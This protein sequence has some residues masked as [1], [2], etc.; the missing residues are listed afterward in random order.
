MKLKRQS[1]CIY[2]CEYHLVLVTKYR[3]KIFNNGIH[4]YMADRLKGL[5]KSYPELEILKINHDEDHIHILISI[6][7]KM[8]VGS[9]V[10]I[11]KS[12]TAKQLKEKFEFLKEVYWGTASI[13]SG[14]YFVS[15]VG[16]DE[17]VIRRYIEM[18]GRE[19]AGQAK[20][21]L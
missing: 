7:P 12:N 15:T 16:L 6:P 14:G 18:Q 21:E 19:D 11:I 5:S 2:R 17:A 4:A 9:V 13:W 3:R 1:N 8:S 20:L 10:R